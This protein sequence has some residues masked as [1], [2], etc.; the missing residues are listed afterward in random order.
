[1]LPRLIGHRGA[2]AHAPENT[3]AGLDAAKRLGMTWVEFDVA[4]SADGHP[5]ILHDESLLRTADLD[6][7]VSEL[8]LA[9]LRRLDAGA[10]FGAGFAGECPPTLEA[11]FDRLAALGLGAN[12]E[13]KPVTGHDAATAAAVVEAVK[14]AWPQ[15]LP[16][17]LLSS[18][19]LTALEVARD[20]GPGVARGYLVDELPPGWQATAARLGA[21]S[22]HPWHE[23]LTAAQVRALKAAGY[24][25][26]V[27]TVNEA[28][29]AKELLAWGVDSVIT[30]DPPAL[31][32]LG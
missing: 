19:S 21:V 9:E 6:R 28:K 3:L 26:V 1:V 18:F 7:L 24:L 10:W 8:T 22:V 32:A 15:A 5:V 13:I 23:P 4:L 25:V 29:R 27:Y 12:I 14:S 31:K 20:L 2:A 16:P 30:D 17:P 11:Y